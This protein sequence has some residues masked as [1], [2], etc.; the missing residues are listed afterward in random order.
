VTAVPLA[1]RVAEHALDRPAEPA[2]AIGGELLDYG[3]LALRAAAVAAGL[4]AAPRARAERPWMPDG[5]R[6]LALAA[7]NQPVFAE[8]FTGATA[9]GS[10]CAVLD[11]RWA[12]EQAHAVLRRLAPDLLVAGQ[13]EGELAATAAGLGI[14]VLTAGDYGTW[15]D[16]WAG[17][18]PAR[19]LVDG[20]DAAAFLVGFTSGTTGLPKAFRQPRRSW[21][22]SLARGR[23]LWGLTAASHTLAP[24]PLSHGLTLYALAECLDA[25]AA[26]HGLPRFDAGHVA[27]VLGEGAVRRLVLVPTML[28]ALAEA[29]GPGAAFP[30]VAGLVSGGAK[31]DPGL[32]EQAR[33]VLPNAR[34]SEYY[35]ASELG[36]VTVASGGDPGAV[37]RPFPGVEVAV[38]DERGAPAPPEA[39]GTVWVRSPLVCDGYLWADEDS[40]FRM[41][42]GWATVGDVGWL[43]RDGELR[44]VGREGGMVVTGGLNV[45]PAEVEAVLRGLDGVDEAVVTGVPDAYLGSMLVAVLSGPGAARLTRAGLLAAC[46][47]RLARHKVPRRLYAARR[48]PLTSS[49]KVARR[50][51]EEWI[52]SGDGRL[53]RIDDA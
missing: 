47:P 25:G 5:G 21:R 45:Y 28:R 19:E 2:F 37:G 6:L 41:A 51:L 24:G 17:A 30:G 46:A 52:A 43:G 33:S 40:G 7:G 20:P 50:V 38:R 27:S 11:P 9:G 13:G 34:L 42:D 49:G 16:R 12:P 15:L 1:G 23:T 14:P 36:F 31:L 29:A 35:G 26:F 53:E 4:R 48:W 22:A 44:L 39:M 8:L 32:A 18:D 3:A 10:A